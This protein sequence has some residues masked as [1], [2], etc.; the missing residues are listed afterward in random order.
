MHSDVL[1]YLLIEELDCNSSNDHIPNWIRIVE[2][3]DNLVIELL[4][5]LGSTKSNKA[6]FRRSVQNT[7]KYKVRLCF[8]I[9]LDII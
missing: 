2:S 9:V 5:L 6:D 8:K 7:I 3:R 4:D 1:Y